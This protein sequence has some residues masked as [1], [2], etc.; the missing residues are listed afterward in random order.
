MTSAD[1]VTSDEFVPDG[2]LLVAHGTRDSAGLA[3]ARRL[4][5]LVSASLAGTQVQ[6]AFLELAEP[7]P[8]TAA[9]TLVLAGCRNVVVAPLLL[10]AAGHAKRDLPEFVAGAAARWPQLEF[11][12]SPAFNC[13]PKLLELSEARFQE[14]QVIA[15]ADANDTLLLLVG[16]GSNDQ[17]ATA[18]MARFARLRWAHWP[19]GA[20][21]VAFVAMAVPPLERALEVAAS[22]PRSNIIVQPHLLFCGEL[23]TRIEELVHA[24][25]EKWPHRRWHL[26]PHLGVDPLLVEAVVDLVKRAAPLTC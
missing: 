1:S 18:E 7:D 12:L 13:H 25:G 8:L 17:E 20:V 21:E 15:E 5:G 4:T 23:L 10:F 2:V 11:K 14:A 22:M 3:E 26:A 16:R 24:A 19:E 9:E 6:L